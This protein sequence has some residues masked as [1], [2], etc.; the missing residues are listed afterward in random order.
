MEN[1]IN[2]ESPRNKFSGKELYD[3]HIVSIPTLLDPIFPK[4]G[5]ILMAGSSD[6]GK[7][8]FLRDFSVSIA[9]GRDDYL[10]FTLNTTHNKVIYYSTEDDED[11][12]AHLL[13]K[14]RGRIDDSAKL[15][16]IKYIFHQND[17]LQELEQELQ[18]NPVDCIIIDALGDILQGN[19]NQANEVRS[20][21]SKYTILANKYDCLIIFL[22]HTNKNSEY[23]LPSK[24]NI[25]GSHGLEAKSRLAIEFRKDQVNPDLRHICI[26]KGNY[27]SEEYKNESFVIRFNSD[28]TYTWTDERVKFS[29]LITGEKNSAKEKAKKRAQE[30]KDDGKP[31]R[32]IAEIITN[33]GYSVS[34]S[35]ISNWLNS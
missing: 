19:I 24:H 1:S 6:T 28:M 33:E 22:H 31:Y 15:D 23:N 5:I 18:E 7:S 16:N 3:R 12:I 2:S 30:L 32:E 35:T 27:L 17:P 14:Q 25:S 20:Y 21:L 9:E 13:Y 10:D 26:V 8:S 11:S 4:K 34:S 29:D